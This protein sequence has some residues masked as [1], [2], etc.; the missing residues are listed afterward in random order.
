[1]NINILKFNGRV[2]L[3]EVSGIPTVHV[4]GFS[5]LV[6]CLFLTYIIYINNIII[7]R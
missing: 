3:Q 4:R 7:I 1:M 2:T 5:Q 6:Y